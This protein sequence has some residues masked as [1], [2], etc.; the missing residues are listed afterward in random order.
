MLTYC[1]N[2][3]KYRMNKG[4]SQQELADMAG[5]KSRSSINKIEKGLT[6][7]TLEQ[8]KK[9]ASILEVDLKDLVPEYEALES[10]SPEK[11]F[12]KRKKIV[13]G[14]DDVIQ[15]LYSRTDDVGIA[16][17]QLA[18]AMMKEERYKAI[19]SMDKDFLIKFRRLNGSNKQLLFNMM[20]TML[21]QQQNAPTT[22]A[23][24]DEGES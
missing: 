2:I 7:L 20:D 17:K 11:L 18:T 6:M 21:Q 13:R 16:F 23:N 1:T 3:R 15:S 22:T 10:S 4:M 9:I 12:E 14:Q 8:A 19:S 5:Y 24:S